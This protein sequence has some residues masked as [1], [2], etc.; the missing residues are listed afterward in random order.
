MKVLWAVLLCAG[1]A[2]VTLAAGPAEAEWLIMHRQAAIYAD[3]MELMPDLQVLKA[4]GTGGQTNALRLTSVSAVMNRVSEGERRMPTGTGSYFVELLSGE[5]IRVGDFTFD[6]T[7]LLA[8]HFFLGKLS[9]PGRKIKRLA[10]AGEIMAPED[11]GFIGIRFMNGDTTKG[12]ILSI[13]VDAAMVDMP[14]IGKIPVGDLGT[15]K[16]FVF[17]GRRAGRRKFYF[18]DRADIEILLKNNEV[19][20]GELK[21]VKGMVWL[22]KPEWRDAPMELPLVFMRAIALHG[23]AVYLPDITPAE[24]ETEPYLNFI[25]PWQR[26]RS[27]SDGRLMT[28]GLAAHRGLATHSRTVLG[29]NLEGL[30]AAPLSFLTVIGM[31]REVRNLDG[32]AD[33]RIELDGKTVFSKRITAAT[34]PVPVRL[35]IP[36]GA[37]KMT[38]AA[39]FAANGSVADHVDWLYPAFVRAK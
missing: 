18:Q 10:R 19:I 17:A 31:D 1:A 14:D 4:V 8:E 3:S 37:K 25:V 29:Y 39:D 28:G 15:V 23:T 13:G 11:S 21:G 20:A 7:T 2:A 36:A 27:L 12:R 26:D 24:Q 38:L 30:T 6:G 35:S 9:L 33:V 16:A 5:R 34:Q 22:L 32:S